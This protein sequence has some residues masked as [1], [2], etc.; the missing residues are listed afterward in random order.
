MLNHKKRLPKEKHILMV[1]TLRTVRS[2]VTEITLA[3]SAKYVMFIDNYSCY[4]CNSK[5]VELKK[6]TFVHK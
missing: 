6:T 5:E 4:W 2:Y 3:V 1:Q